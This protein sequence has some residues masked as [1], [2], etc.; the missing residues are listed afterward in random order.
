VRVLYIHTTPYIPAA[1]Q[2]ALSSS[3]LLLHFPNLVHDI[4]YGSPIG[5]PPPL[6]KTF[7]PPNL[8]SA[9]IHPEIIEQELLDE[10]SANRMSGPFSLNQASIIFGGPF[11][12]SP[13]GLVEKVPGDG[14][15]RMIRHLSKQD[16][17][18]F[19]TNDWLDSGEFPTSYF[20][21]SWVSQFVSLRFHLSPSPPFVLFVAACVPRPR[22]PKARTCLTCITS[23]RACV[24]RLLG[25]VCHVFESQCARCLLVAA[26]LVLDGQCARTI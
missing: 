12:S 15:W 4:T 13:V 21:A 18:S 16:C 7:L 20:A 8:A 1:W 26:R 25:P 22:W 24:P 9:L 19:S 5:N 14:N 23:S 17:D 11:R 2:D 6:S 10:V 3:R